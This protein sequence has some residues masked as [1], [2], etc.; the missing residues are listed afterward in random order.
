LAS[1]LTWSTVLAPAFG[2]ALAAIV[3]SLAPPSA[4]VVG[5]AWRLGLL[6]ALRV[7]RLRLWTAL[8]AAAAAVAA[9]QAGDQ[10][11]ILGRLVLG[12]RLH[13]A[14]EHLRL[15]LMLILLLLLAESGFFGLGFHVA[16]GVAG[17]FGQ[18]DLGVE[19]LDDALLHQLAE[20]GGDGVGYVAMELGAAVGLAAVSHRRKL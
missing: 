18:L 10:G 14:I 7:L 17:L 15:I 13:G 2:L 16:R 1:F 19:C 12:L 3:A 4:A 5:A 6:R 8:P 20:L 9:I 11:V